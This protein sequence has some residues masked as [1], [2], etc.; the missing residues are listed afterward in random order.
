MKTKYLNI[1]QHVGIIL[2]GNGRW[3][4][5]KHLKRLD[6]HKKGVEAVKNTIKA[7]IKFGIKVLSLYA[8][9]TENW[10][11]SEEEVNGIFKLLEVAIKENKQSFIK[12][13]IKV[14]IMGDYLKL[15]QSLHA[16]L[17][18]V[19]EETKNNSGLI[20]NIG[21]NYG[22]RDEILRAVNLCLK[23]HNGEVIDKTTFENYLYTSSL[24]PLDFIIRTSGEMRLSNFMLYQ[25]AYAE[26][27]F[28]KIYWPQFNEKFLLKA[29]KE[30]NNRNRRF[31]NA[32]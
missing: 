9:S 8:F 31:G 12:N 17:E 23:N 6:G 29:I 21:L 27:Y 32:K 13:N 7:S 4:K 30:F 28:P 15:P 26:L 19:I 25:A 20:L 5:G 22:S 16:E 1:P 10:K 2:D 3:A 11:R 14:M 24:P 18:N